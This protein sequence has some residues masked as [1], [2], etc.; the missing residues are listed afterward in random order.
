MTWTIKIP[1]NKYKWYCTKAFGMR[2]EWEWHRQGRN[3]VK[4]IMFGDGSKNMRWRNKLAVEH[5][6]FC[7]C[8]TARTRK[9][10]SLFTLKAEKGRYIFLSSGCCFGQ[11]VRLCMPCGVLVWNTLVYIY[12]RTIAWGIRFE[13]SWT[14]MR[15]YDGYFLT[16][17]KS[18][19]LCCYC[20]CC[21]CCFFVSVTSALFLCSKWIK[22]IQ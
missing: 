6:F 11:C 13:L 4:A 21:R 22:Y 5:F 18:K 19:L 14:H 7:C 8:S 9:K 3:A 2:K 20:C 15:P 1:K 12:L 10:Y 17:S 16:N